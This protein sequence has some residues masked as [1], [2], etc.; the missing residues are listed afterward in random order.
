ML[1]G[2]F[3]TQVLADLGARVIKIERPDGDDA[4]A[5]GPFV[6]E[7][8]AYFMSINRNKESIA[9]DLKRGA[10]R[11][12]FEKLLQRADVLV[13]NFRPGTLEKLGY[14]WA[15]LS[16]THPRLVLASISG[17]GQSGP[18]S[19]RP[20]YD[21][22]VQAMSGMMSVTG[23]PGHPP[24]R[25]G[26]SIGDLAAGLYGAIA[27]QAALLR[28][29]RTGSGEWV[30]VAMLDCQVALLENALARFHVTGVTPG[31]NGAR[32]PSIT[33]F[34]MFRTADGWIAIAVGNDELFGQLC[35]L[36]CI[37]EAANDPRFASMRTRGEHHEALKELIERQLAQKCC[38]QWCELFTTEGIPSGPYNTIKELVDD[39]Q[40]RARAMLMPLPYGADKALTVAGNPIKFASIPEDSLRAAPLL[41]EHREQILAELGLST[42]PLSQGAPT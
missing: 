21:M 28:R 17:F 13:E 9:L 3:C 41:D 34:D 10:D 14:A 7:Q 35:G 1:S 25:V 37:P 11:V 40:L 26:T 22:V 29:H 32:H 19:R 20:A 16:S 18:Y 33:P 38:A 23:Q 2:P 36:L 42:G 39:P 31:P 24:T 5:I 27:I 6:D 30:D 4:R 8:S 12:V 15:A